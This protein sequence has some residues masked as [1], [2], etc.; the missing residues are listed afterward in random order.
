MVHKKIALIIVT[1]LCVSAC[2]NGC[3]K[4]EEPVPLP[5]PEAVEETEPEPEEEPE[6]EIVEEP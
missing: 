6:P 3:G 4:K 1:V 5:E 2:L